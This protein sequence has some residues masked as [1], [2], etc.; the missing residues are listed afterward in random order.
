MAITLSSRVVSELNVLLVSMFDKGASDAA[1]RT[2]D[3]INLAYATGSDTT[4]NVY[5]MVDSDF[6][7]RERG[8]SAEMIVDGVKMYETRVKNGDFYKLI[9]VDLNAFEDDKVGQFGSV[10][11]KLGQ[12]QAV[13]PSRLMEDTILASETVAPLG[14]YDGV[15]LIS[16]AHPLK[17]GESGSTTWS[18]KLTKSAG[19]TFTTFAEAY[20][21]FQAFPGEDGRPLGNLPTVLVCA[22]E[23]RQIAHDICFSDRPQD[24]S[25]GGNAWKGEVR[26]M[27]VPRLS[28]ADGW[29]LADDSSS[30]ERPWIF[31]ERRALRMTPLFSSHED[32]AVLKSHKLSWMVD[33]RLGAGYGYAN[34]VIK[35]VKA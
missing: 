18:N 31:Q 34:R 23:Y 11:Y 22:P 33:G 9:E 28:T 16:T 27:I 21:A 24:G 17:P 15:A 29:Y 32:P 14:N 4:T 20:A 7:L 25:G 26:P 2:S 12:A 3:V 10:F 35:V 5:T 8:D 30:M 13:G 19:L 6:S 1:K